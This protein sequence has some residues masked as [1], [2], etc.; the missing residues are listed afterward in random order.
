[1]KALF[2]RV[3]FKQEPLFRE[4]CAQHSP[5]T[6][7]MLTEYDQFQRSL[8]PWL[9]GSAVGLNLLWWAMPTLGA[10]VALALT[11]TIL[12]LLVRDRKREASWAQRYPNIES[13]DVPLWWA[14]W[15]K[16]GCRLNEEQLV[17]EWPLSQLE[18]LVLTD[19]L[20]RLERLGADVLS[21]RQSISAF[22]YVHQHHA[23][24]W[25]VLREQWKLKESNTQEAGP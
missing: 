3:W 13:I 23:S 7:A 10:F 14:G 4:A 9:I 16:A 11:V 24:Q 25:Q 2:W 15:K 21:L 19:D 12:I 18:A 22:G 20:M 5:V 8:A 1:M 6:Q 17:Q